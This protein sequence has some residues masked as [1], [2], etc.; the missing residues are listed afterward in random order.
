MRGP[1]RGS[2][3]GAPA[4]A[5][6]PV[7][8]SGGSWW[9]TPRVGLDP[10]VW[11]I[12]FA[13]VGVFALLLRW[14]FGPAHPTRYGLLVTVATL[15]EGAAQAL[16]TRLQ[17]AGIRATIADA[18]TGYDADGT[19]WVERARHVLVFPAD[20]AIARNLVRAPQPA[21]GPPA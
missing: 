2:Q 4:A 21:P 10:T 9:Q 7:Q 12:G 15:R 3:L 13:V 18:G 19:R 1:G 14:V 8:G 6:G 17:R 11:P 20:A 5:V 16:L